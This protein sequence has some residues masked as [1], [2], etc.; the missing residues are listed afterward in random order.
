MI[1]RLYSG[2]DGQSHFE[3]LS[4][5]MPGSQESPLQ[6]A[7]GITFRRQQP[8]LFLDWHPAPRRQWV[9]TLTGTAEIGIG[10][11]TIKRFEPGDAMLAEDLTG[12]GHTTRVVGEEPRISV[13]I[14]VA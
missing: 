14:P 4:L 1:V 10:D 9:I 7:K 11:G 2:T 12:K 5:P 13:A 8:G 3:D 6:Q